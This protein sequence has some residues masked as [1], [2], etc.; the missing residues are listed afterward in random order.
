MNLSA[1]SAAY[2]SLTR[3]WGTRPFVL[4]AKKNPAAVLPGTTPLMLE[5][6]LAQQ[7]VEDIRSYLLNETSRLAAGRERL[8][9]RDFTSAERYEASITPNRKHL[10]EIIGAVDSRAAFEPTSL[11]ANDWT[12]T[13]VG[14]G[15]GFHIYAIRWPVFAAPTADAD[16]MEAEGLLLH[17]DHPPVA[18]AVAIPD[19]D[20]T[21]EMLAGIAD[22]VPDASQFARRL[23]ENDVQVI[24]PLLMNRDDTF[25]GIPGIGMTNMPHREWIYRMAFEVGRHIIGLEVQKILAAVDWFERKGA[26]E[27]LPIGVMGYG[28]GGLLALYSASLDPRIRA[29]VVSGYF[30]P[31]ENVWKEPIYRDVWSLVREFGDA[32]LASMIAPRVLIVEACRGPVVDGPP[33]VTGEHA[34]CAC[35]NG[36][37]TTAPLNEVQREVERASQ[38]FKQLNAE[39]NLQLIAAN[40]AM[41]STG[42]EPAILAF[43]GALGAGKGSIS[44]IGSPP[45]ATISFDPASRLHNQFDQLVAFTQALIRKSPDNRAEFWKNA[46]AS[47]LKSWQVSTQSCRDYIWEE[48]IGR[49]PAPTLPPNPRSRMVFDEPGFRGYEI[50]LDVWPGVFAY[51]ILLVPTSLKPGEKRPVV[52]CQ[53]GLEGRP[54]EITDPHID[55]HFYHHFGASLADEG[56]VIF[57]P[58][59][60]YI[61]QDNFRIIQRIG[62]PIG[63]SLFSFIL[64]QHQQIL[65][66]LSAQPFVDSDRIGFYGLSYGGKT[67]V[68]VPPLIDGYCLSIC[69]GDFNE[70]I[71][72]TTNVLTAKT[73]MLLG[74]YD[75]Y[76]YNFAN[77]MNYSDLA[78][79]MA[80]KP[81]MV[82][83]GHDDPVG[84]DQ[85]VSYEYALVREFYDKLG[86]G[87]RTEIEFF[88]GPHEIH[89]VGTFQFLRKHLRPPLESNRS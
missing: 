77:I 18:R 21:P 66:W 15:H 53:H 80:P 51:G 78:N 65:K 1:G 23:A 31:R 54:N 12:Q 36:K 30:Q 6:D 67:A 73:Y 68:R 63:L 57:A 69:S 34:A 35:P 85:W 14:R 42:S 47:S 86:I 33:P 2:G 46:D 49:L 62:H 28:E 20:W 32:E 5:G 4:D 26:T 88:N 41:G 27:S 13:E 39:A 74:E 84:A 61:G 45:K 40:G 87:D 48:V 64:G 59:N 38:F 79:L 19:A 24:I 89:G 43:L 56:F 71:W 52:V 25:S 44:A 7:M 55:S 22:G 83:R 10:R 70:W 81:F 50:V 72:K 8:W 3:L 37:L 58:Q 60:P 75:M 17:P 16:G 29:A 11:S 76:E 9:K 82:E